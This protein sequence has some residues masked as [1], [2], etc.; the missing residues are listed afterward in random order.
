M[1]ELQKTISKTRHFW[2]P[3]S[4]VAGLF[5]ILGF[6]TWLNGSLMPYLKQVIQLSAFEATLIIFSFYIAVTFSAIPSALLIGKIGYKR[7]MSVGLAI[8]AIGAVLFAPAARM[9]LFSLF[10]IAQLIMGIGQTLLQTAVNPYVIQLGE[11]KS[12]AVR[13]SIMGILSKSAGILAPLVFT[14]LIL[15]EFKDTT[16]IALTPIDISNMIEHLIT[17]YLSMAFIL[18]ILACIIFILPLPT[19]QKG[20]AKT[21]MDWHSIIECLRYPHL[22]LGVLAI[23]L[24]VGVEVIAAD[25]VGTFALS[26]HI[27]N[28]SVMTAYTMAFM[29]LGYLCGIASIPRLLSQEQA[30]TLSAV[31]GVIISIGI[32][33]SSP[34]SYWFATHI[35]HIG[36][37]QALP[38]TLYLITLLGFAN[39]IVWPAVWP[40][41]L[42]GLGNLTSTASGLLVM[43]IAGG[44]ILPLLWGYLS[45]TSLGMHNA[46]MILIPCYLYILFYAIKGCR[47]KK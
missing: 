45:E 17:P 36:A 32:L 46:Y 37:F 34:E 24:Y 8:M 26:L 47:L 30:L 18:L 43:G 1:V 15:G 13:V 22:R 11:E 16:H 3:M 4:V 31:L 42:S 14:A 33:I 23:F 9:Q 41:A 20:T 40:L 44:A 38:D 35:A 28:Y 21:N 6:T 19:I 10:L 25:T 27:P 29:V 39:A 7:G 5:F 12:A 2:F